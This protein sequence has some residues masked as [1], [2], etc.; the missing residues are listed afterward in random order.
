MLSLF[1]L[2]LVVSTTT[3]FKFMSG[4]KM[5]SIRDMAEEAAVQEKFG[6]KSESNMPTAK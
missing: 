5:P 2:F 6:E 3:A 1:C 4:W